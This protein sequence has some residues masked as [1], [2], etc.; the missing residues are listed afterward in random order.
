MD[1]LHTLTIGAALALAACTA[2]GCKK[3]RGGSHDD[4]PP[5]APAGRVDAVKTIARQPVTVEE[6]CDVHK[7]PQSAAALTLPALAAGQTAPAAGSWRWINVWAPW[8]VPCT[9]E[10][11]K[12]V[13]WRNT[14]A[15]QGTKVDLVFLS[16]EPGDDKLAAALKADPR[17]LSLRMANQDD[18]SPWLTSLGLNDGAPIPVHLF[19]DPANKV[20]CVRSG[21]LKESDV[22]AI[23]TLL[24]S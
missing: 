15:G 18:L 7:D 19:V 14:L 4:Q 21:A 17:P 20:R 16:A 3:D 22:P 10:M 6:L 13:T 12:L 9:D 24:G 8:C 11:P 5:A 23:A 2:A 1:R